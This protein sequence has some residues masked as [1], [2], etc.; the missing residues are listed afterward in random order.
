MYI[1]LKISCEHFISKYFK[2]KTKNKK[3]ISHKFQEYANNICV[4]AKQVSTQVISPGS[5]LFVFLVPEYGAA[6]DLLQG[7][8]D[9]GHLVNPVPL[10]RVLLFYRVAC[11]LVEI[12]V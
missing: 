4:P 9:L 1:S 12:K 8:E 6:V 2:N 11:G 7:F 5:V 3:N 10:G